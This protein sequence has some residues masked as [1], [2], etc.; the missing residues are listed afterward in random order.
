MSESLNNRLKFNKK[1]IQGRFIL[2]AENKL[3]LTR[4]EFAKKLKISK[5][6][7]ADW[8]REEVTVSETSAKLISK[9]AKIPIPKNHKVINWRIHLRNAGRIGSRVKFE[10]YGSVGGDEKHRKEKWREWWDRV[11]QYK[12]PAKGFTTLIKIRL[13][14][15]SKE[16]AEFIGIL[17]GDGHIAKYQVTITLSSKE[18][19]YIQFVQMMI[20]NLFGVIPMI[21]EHKTSKA[22]TIIV[23]RKLLVD[24]C[25]R[26]GFQRGNKIA[27]QVDIPK[28]IKENKTF[29]QACLRGLID[30]DGCFFVHKYM[31]FRKKYSYL[32]IA[33][34]SASAPL[35][36][37]VG[38]I[39]INL[40]FNVRMSAERKN[41][42][43]RDIRI[44]DLKSMAKYVIEIG[45][46][47]QKHLDKI[48]KW[49]VALN[50]KAAVC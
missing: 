22:V 2:D 20:K 48:E 43:G 21:L 13:P 17:L 3:R 16:L 33:F 25:E 24:F 28:W 35:L 19:Q 12:K 9:L 7:L 10:K 26:V 44:E 50:G 32:K 30:T 4:S 40:G 46:H 23:S 5:R 18:K 34:T 41:S 11:G 14:R 29:S 49:K 47:N 36:E 45:S 27:H 37:S 15:K 42:N 31:S 8:K 38:N 1:G 39:L 6:T